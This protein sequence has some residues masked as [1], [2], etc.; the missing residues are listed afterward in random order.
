MKN[1]QNIWL[2]ALTAAVILLAVTLADTHG[3]LTALQAEHTALQQETEDLRERLSETREQLWEQEDALREVSAQVT[4]QEE[5]PLLASYTLTPLRLEAASHQVELG[6]SLSLTTPDQTA[7]AT[8]NVYQGGGERKRLSQTELTRNASGTYAGEMAVPAECTNLQ[9]L[10]T[11]RS[12]GSTDTA[13]L[14]EGRAAGLLPVT[15][16]G[17]SGN[18]SRQDGGA[19]IT[20]AVRLGEPVSASGQAF[21][22]YCN[23]RLAE[24]VP[25]VAGQESGTWEGTGTLSCADG[26]QVEV[27]FFCEDDLGLGYEFPVRVWEVKEDRIAAGWPVT[28]A[29]ELV[30]PE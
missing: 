8:V 25:A 28:Y 7:T 21:R 4:Q 6:I 14:Y 11:V 5:E 30:W 29:P 20:A 3:R 27:R 22:L 2:G 18:G 12:E 17:R 10:V 9:I 16:S 23:G 1:R 26:D 15:L 13:W 19:E 24:T